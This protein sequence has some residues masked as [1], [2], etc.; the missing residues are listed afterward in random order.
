[1]KRFRI[2]LVLIGAVTM[3]TAIAEGQSPSSDHAH[4]SHSATSAPAANASVAYMDAM[5]RMEEEMA[6]MSMTNE[7]GKDFA[8][9]MIPHHR[10]AIDMARA[11]LDSG[12]NDPTITRIARDVVASQEREIGELTDWLRQRRSE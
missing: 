8:R 1:M 11:Y 10:S 3:S 2:T 4:G 12:E 9:M 7:P 6:S 5:K